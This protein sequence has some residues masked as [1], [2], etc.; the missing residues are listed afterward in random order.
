MINWDKPLQTLDN[1][2]AKLCFIRQDGV[3]MVCLY[4]PPS[5]YGVYS[6]TLNGLYQ[7]SENNPK[8]V[9][10][11][12]NKS[13]VKWRWFVEKIAIHRYMTTSI[14]ITCDYYESAEEVSKKCSTSVIL[15]KAEETRKEFDL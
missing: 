7:G 15:G 4:A 9:A 2:D 12:K 6:Y 5:H 3:H 14:D 13:V 8:Y 10:H 1:R 11:L